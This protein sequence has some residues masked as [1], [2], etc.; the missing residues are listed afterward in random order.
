[1]SIRPDEDPQTSPNVDPDA[2]E[3]APRPGEADPSEPQRVLEPEAPT[4]APD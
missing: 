1:M 3:F 2:P 4:H